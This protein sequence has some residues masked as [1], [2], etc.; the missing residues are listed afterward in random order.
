MTASVSGPLTPLPP[1]SAPPPPSTPP[2]RPGR[3]ALLATAIAATGFAL[4]AF[5]IA[6]AARVELLAADF[7]ARDRVDLA[8]WHH[9]RLAARDQVGRGTSQH[10]I[11]LQVAQQAFEDLQLSNINA[12]AARQIT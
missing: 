2:R 6:A 12:G 9:Y 10:R 11:D 7:L 4:A 5:A 1:P 3:P 8:D